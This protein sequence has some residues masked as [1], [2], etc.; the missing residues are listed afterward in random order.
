MAYVYD[1]IEYG[2][3]FRDVYQMEELTGHSA[4]S[5]YLRSEGDYHHAVRHVDLHIPD[6]P[7]YGFHWDRAAR[8]EANPVNSTVTEFVIDNVLP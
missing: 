2:V 5:L 4:I 8:D 6:P 3:V 7:V 1:S